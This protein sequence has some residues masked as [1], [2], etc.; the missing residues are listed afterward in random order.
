MN[1]KNGSV[2]AKNMAE[3]VEDIQVDFHFA[4]PQLNMEQMT[5]KIDTLH[6]KMGADEISAAI[7]EKGM[8]KPFIN[9]NINAHL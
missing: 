1:V 7:E 4:M 5:V 9:G 3:P 8:S 2:A 6:A